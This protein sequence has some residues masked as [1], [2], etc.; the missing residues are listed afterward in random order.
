MNFS[1]I[2]EYCS[3]VYDDE[4]FQNN[5]ILKIDTKDELQWGFRFSSETNELYIAFRGSY[6]ADNWLANINIFPTWLSGVGGVHRGFMGAS[7]SIIPFLDPIISHAKDHKFRIVFC[8]HSLG[9]AIAQI[10][11]EIIS[12]SYPNVRIVSIGSPKVFTR[13]AKVRAKHFRL[14]IDDDPIPKLMGFLFKHYEYAL[15]ERTTEGVISIADHSCK[16]YREV[17]KDV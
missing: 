1:K 11:G 14:I 5:G 17:F 12:K 7:Q 15:L 13:F 3:A 4:D 16:H 8:G 10:I 9:G 2:I 6:N